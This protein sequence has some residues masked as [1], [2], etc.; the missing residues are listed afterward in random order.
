MERTRR[1]EWGQLG[2]FADGVS[3]PDGILAELVGALAELLL[4]AAG[5]R[6]GGGREGGSDHESEDHT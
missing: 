5:V 3:I 2:L 6:G 1:T 4:E